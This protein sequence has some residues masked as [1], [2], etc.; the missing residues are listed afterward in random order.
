MY[1]SKSHYP[2]LGDCRTA[3]ELPT[4][5]ACDPIQVVNETYC[6]AIN[7]E[8]PERIPVAMHSNGPKCDNFCPCVRWNSKAS[9]LKQFVDAEIENQ[10]G[11]EFKDLKTNLKVLFYNPSLN[12]LTDIV[13]NGFC[14]AKQLFDVPNAGC[15]VK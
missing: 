13:V 5:L 9:K 15:M 2:V 1:I 4:Y 6:H 14:S 12:K 3:M 7:K 11:I 8:I 10:K